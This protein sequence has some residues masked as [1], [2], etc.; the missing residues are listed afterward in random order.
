MKKNLFYISSFLFCHFIGYS[1]N[2]NIYN[3]KKHG[4]TSDDDFWRMLPTPDNSGYILF[5]ES[6]SG[7]SG[8][9]TE[10]NR[11]MTDLWISKV[12]LNLDPV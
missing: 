6:N 7:I 1:Q 11:G 12:D 10:V 2:P 4:G 8:T 3:Q 5:G 9:K